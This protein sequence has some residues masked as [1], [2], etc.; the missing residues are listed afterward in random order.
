[1]KGNKLLVIFAISAL[2]V[3]ISATN[4]A[5]ADD[6]SDNDEERKEKIAKDKEFKKELKKQWNEQWNV[7]VMEDI[8]QHP[9]RWLFTVLLII[10]VSILLVK[11]YP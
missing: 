2:L 10:I 7:N 4:F 1:M 6:S 11:M 8:K 3:S 5:Y 9:I